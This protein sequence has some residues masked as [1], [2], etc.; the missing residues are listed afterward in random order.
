MSRVADVRA[1]LLFGAIAAM[2]GLC[3][4]Q[5]SQPASSPAS[6]QATSTPATSAATSSAASQPAQKEHYLAV[7]HGQV[8]TGAGPVLNDATILC[9]NGKI[10]AIGAD[11]I[12]PPE[13]EVIDA[14][15]RR[16][17][18]GL[19]L[20]GASGFLGDNAADTAD[21][22]S[23][24]MRLA[25][26]G[27]VTAT[28]ADNDVIKLTFGAVDDM[29]LRKEALLDLSYST[30]RP[31][32]R[33]E[34]RSDF[35]R[36]R[37]YQRELADYEEKKKT[38][39]DAKPPERD[40]IK[41]KLA[42]YQKLLKG[43]LTAIASANTADE[44]VALAELA[45]RYGFRVIARGAREGWTVAERLGRSGV[46]AVVTPRDTAEPDE[47]VNRPTGSSIE[48]A[49]IL[50]AAGVRVAL[51]PTIN[52]I[53]GIG[54]RGVMHLNME[55]AFAVRGGLS[56]EDAIRAITIDP[57]RMLGVDDRIGSIEAGKDADLLICDG[58]LLSFMTQVN[59]TIV[60]GRL[61][62]DKAK[63][64]FFAHIRPEGREEPV[65]FDDLWPRRLEW[66]AEEPA[67]NPA[68]SAP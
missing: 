18:P 63:D 66:P 28:L 32:D 50:R 6:S 55:G 25:A 21:V 57:A 62:Y 35:E 60:N 23:I 33:A 58:D 30:R 45:E 27:G 39:K 16:V 47:T 37:K 56:P 52:G 67:H 38:D 4:A 68:T 31:L 53:W 49:R 41:G 54:G 8:H 11:L 29:T 10:V 44:L 36:L 2:S 40:W 43:E 65:K 22:F 3:L 12:L 42:N 26:A 46:S 5:E 34:L 61:T 19:V 51:F 59:Y 48:N 17:Y 1:A 14:T 24:G 7:V 13:C 15:G 64:T 9:R 20:A